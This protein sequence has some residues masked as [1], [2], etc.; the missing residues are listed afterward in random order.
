[1]D[2]TVELK[3]SQTAAK[4]LFTRANNILHKSMKVDDHWELVSK[5]FD[6][7]QKRYNDLQEKHE[8]YLIELEE[9][10]DFDATEQNEWMETIQDEFDESERHCHDYIKNCKQNLNT[11]SE[12]EEFHERDTKATVKICSENESFKKLRQFEKSELQNEVQKIE[13][14]LANNDIDKPSKTQLLKEYQSELKKQVE[15]CKNVQSQY[16]SHS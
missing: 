6:D 10:P 4:R 9:G 15:R 2:S 13:N 16:F 12:T 3:K 11:T 7:L 1:M 8:L 5:K 14:L